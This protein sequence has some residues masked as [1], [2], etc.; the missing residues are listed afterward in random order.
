[1]FLRD[2][3]SKQKLPAVLFSVFVLLMFSLNFVFVFESS[4]LPP[5]IQSTTIDMDDENTY[6]IRR[7][8]TY[9]V[10]YEGNYLTSVSEVFDSS[11]PVYEED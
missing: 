1:M 7:G 5:N 8:D 11:I 2:E 9:D 6:L 10:Y 3:E 4:Y